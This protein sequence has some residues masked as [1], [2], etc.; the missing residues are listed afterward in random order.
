MATNQQEV[1]A[2]SATKEGELKRTMTFFPALSTVMGTV[3]GAGVFFKAAS[4]AAVTGSTSM[5]MLSWF[6][7]GLISVCAGLTGAELAAAIPETGGMLRYI[8]RAYGK[9]PSFLLGWA[10]V[11]IYFPANVAAL[12]IIFATQFKNLFGLGDG[13]IIPI[14]IVAAASIM[15]INFLGSKAGGMFQSVTLVFKLI[16]LALIVIFGL[17]REGAVE[18]SLFP[19]QAGAN[20]G[21]FAP[22]LGAGLLAT[23]FAYDGWIHVG[24]LAGELKKPAKDLPRAIAGGI[25]GIMVVY[26]LVNWAYL[27]TMAI[28]ELAGNE[29][30]AM[31]VAGRIFGGMGGRLVTIGILVSVYGTI[32]GYTMT[33]MRLPYT[34]GIEK[35]L[36]FSKQLAKLNRNSVPYIAGILELVI[37]IG[38]MMVGGFDL[39]TDMLVFVIWIFYTLVFIAVIKLRKTEPDLHRPY[40][41]PLYPIIPAVAIVG[42]VF[43]LIMTLINQFSLAMVGLLITALGIP[44]YFYMTKK[45]QQA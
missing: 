8:E 24:N 12:S 35:Q 16:P 30:A 43:I 17:M 11:I 18:V 36:P 13:T 9:F 45:N 1:A 19:V 3:I 39:L 44:V 28:P 20:V 27:K 37:A 40:K 5:H 22:A 25:L 23:M 2:S 4:V 33:G 6:L 42:G 7:G 32:N 38:M 21:G 10:Q 14:A 15:L 41:V 26:L 29:N 34:M 31:E